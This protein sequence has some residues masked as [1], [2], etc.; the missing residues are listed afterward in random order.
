MMPRVCFHSAVSN[1]RAIFSI[2]ASS[3]ATPFSTSSL[4]AIADALLPFSD[5]QPSGVCSSIPSALSGALLPHRY[6]R[7]ERSRRLA[8]SRAANG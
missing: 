6:C 2:F 5:R 8:E 3:S 4:V 1:R 7:E